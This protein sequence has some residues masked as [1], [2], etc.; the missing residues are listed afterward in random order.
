VKYGP[1]QPQQQQLHWASDY[2]LRALTDLIY[3]KIR[4]TSIFCKV[5][6]D[7]A[8]D[9]QQE[10]TAAAATATTIALGT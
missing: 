8:T 2:T 5:W 9:T 10:W 7:A 1:L 4:L 6:T 3:L